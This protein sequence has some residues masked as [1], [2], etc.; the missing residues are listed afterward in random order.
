MAD[1]TP[2]FRKS[3]ESSEA[4]AARNEKWIVGAIL[5]GFLAVCLNAIHNHGYDGQDFAFHRKYTECLLANPKAWFYKSMTDRPL[6]YWIGG[7]CVTLAHWN[8]GYLLASILFSISGT[9]ALAIMYAASRRFIHSPLLRCSAL[10]FIAFLPVTVVTTVVYAADTVA[11]L[12][13]ALGGWSLVKA[14]E[15]TTPWPTFRYAAL[16]GI[17]LSIGSFGKATFLTLSLAALTSVALLLLWK[18]TTPSRS[19]FILLFCSLTPGLVGIWL[20]LECKQALRNEPQAHNFN[21]H[22][23]G[24]M[25][26]RSLLLPYRGDVRIFAAPSYWDKDPDDSLPLLKPNHYSYPALLHLAIFTDISGYTN[27]DHDAFGARR[28]EPQKTEARLAV[29]GGL[30]FS[31]STVAVVLAFFIQLSRA[32]LRRT[33]LSEPSLSMWFLFAVF[34]YVPLVVL[35]PYVHNSYYYGYWLP[36]LTL[37]ALWCFFLMLFATADALPP[38]WSRPAAGVLTLLAAIQTSLD[39]T[40]IW[41]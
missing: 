13:F 33:P 32:C 14:S 6:L 31:F 22:G 2:S 37:P 8:H 20:A 30:F 1:F 10:A 41:F 12:P 25:T 36:R 16:S 21:W 27:I 40:S 28:P 24:E 34:W 9:A 35:L 39:I 5:A 15:A 26:W 23:T 3:C 7:A 17:A 38:R 4:F 11:L 19:I 29:C 18:K